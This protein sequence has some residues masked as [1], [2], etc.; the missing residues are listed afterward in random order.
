MDGLS[1]TVTTNVEHCLRSGVKIVNFMM[2]PIIEL[3]ILNKRLISEKDLDL[4]HLRW[5]LK[6]KSLK[7]IIVFLW[8]LHFSWNQLLLECLLKFLK[9]INDDNP[10]THSL[11]GYMINQAKQQSI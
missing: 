3:I 6:P 11:I 7:Y 4:H 1:L 10:K 2:Q 9:N 5:L 8:N